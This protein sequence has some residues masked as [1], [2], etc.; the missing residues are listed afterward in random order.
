MYLNT[1]PPSHCPYTANCISRK[2]S[3]VK[4]HGCIEGKGLL[5]GQ[6]EPLQRSTQVLSSPIKLKLITDSLPSLPWDWQIF[7]KTS[8]K[9][10]HS[11][12]GLLRKLARDAAL[13]FG[14]P[15]LFRCHSLIAVTEPTEFHCFFTCSSYHKQTNYNLF[16]ICTWV[17]QRRT[18]KF[19]NRLK[20]KKEFKLCP[21]TWNL[22]GSLTFH[23]VIWS[24]LKLAQ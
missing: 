6:W 8:R 12:G 18:C 10:T 1:E 17:V 19:R 11:G 13:L 7:E 2:F 5:V 9:V 14:F 22:Y 20:L 21:C 3:A 24:R 16:V 23:K 15:R 4:R